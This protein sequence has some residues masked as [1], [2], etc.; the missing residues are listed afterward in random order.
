MILNERITNYEI[1]TKENQFQMEQDAHEIRNLRAELTKLQE[2]KALQEEQINQSNTTLKQSLE[3]LQNES[4]DRSIVFFL[5][6]LRRCPVVPHL[7]ACSF[8]SYLSMP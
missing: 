6:F 1:Q 2:E 5:C 7:S 3:K 4:N 8:L